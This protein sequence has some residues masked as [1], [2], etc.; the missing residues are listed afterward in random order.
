MGAAYFYHLTRH[1]L[2]TTLPQLL[3]KAL[4][5]GWRCQVI[6]RD[7][8]RSQHLDRSLWL[9]KESDFLAHGIAGGAH[10]A[11]QPVLL[12]T[13]RSSLQTAQCVMCIDGAEITAEDVQS[14]DRTCILFDGNDDAQVQLARGQWKQ[15][16]DAGCTAQYWSEESGNWQ[17]K[18]EKN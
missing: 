13:E 17:K 5:A 12:A 4:A 3:S 2:D 16:T 11:D 1:P 8:A 6:G 10:D 7:P 18:A 9:G 14:L 15:L